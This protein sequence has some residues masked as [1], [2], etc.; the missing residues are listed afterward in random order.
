MQHQRHV[1][2]LGVA[3][4][5]GRACRAGVTGDQVE[6]T[7]GTAGGSHQFDDA[8]TQLACYPD[9]G[10]LRAA[11]DDQDLGIEVVQIELELLAT[12]GRIERSGRRAGGDG[13]EAGGHLGPVGQH[14]GHAV[15]AAYAQR[16]QAGNRLAD[17]GTQ[18][19]VA[20]YR[21][22]RRADGG[23]GVVAGGEQRFESYGVRHGISLG[24]TAVAL[25]MQ[26]R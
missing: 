12:V 21:T 16:I 1:V 22:A 17:Q 23:R 3:G 13:D 15:V 14:D 5:R 6:I 26:L 25:L 24:A 2:G 18:L 10:R 19:P 11:L 7:G 4:I 9:G 8:H 20:E